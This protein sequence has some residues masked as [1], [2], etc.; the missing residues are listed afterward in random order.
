MD[1]ALLDQ[2]N[3]E[4]KKAV[5]H[6]E[7]P[8]LI[9]AGAGT[10]KTTVITKRI[11]WLIDQGLAKPEEI[12][13]LTFT[14]KAAGE[15]EERVDL[16]LPY[17]YVDLQ[18]ST[19]HA[20]CE[21]LL[22]DFGTQIGLSHQF[23]VLD[24]LETWL[25]ARQK[26]DRFDLDY[27]RPLG[28]PT[29][30]LRG[31]LAHFSRAKDHHITPETY[32]AFAESLQADADH[33][34]AD[35]SSDMEA[36]RIFELATAYQTYQQVLLEQDALDF[37]DL[38]LYTLKLLQERPNVLQQLRARYRFIL[39][40]EFQDTNPAQYELV[41]LLSEPRNNL[42]VVGDDDQAIYKFR[43]ASIENIL[44]FESDYPKAAR[45]V[46]TQNYRSVQAILD[47]A[48]TF[49][50][51]NNPDRLEARSGGSL[52]K[53]L[54][55]NQ[56]GAGLIEHL[57]FAT[58]EEE[59]REVIKKILALKAADP[60][61]LWSDIAVLV[62][63][64]G[65]G[66]DF[67]HGF[68]RSG[69][70]F[71]FLA[72]SGLYRKP[73]VVDLMSLLRVI[74][75][76]HDSPSLYRVLFLPMW[77]IP[78]EVL[79]ELSRLATRKGKSLFETIALAGTLGA[80]PLEPIVR[81]REISHLLLELSNEAKTKTASELF[82]RALKQTK[83]IDVITTLDD[84][85]KKEIFGY[86][87]QMLERVKSFEKRSPLPS[88]HE[89][90]AE[91]RHEQDAG[92]EGSLSVDIEAGPDVVRLMTV[93]AAKG[94]EFKYVF[95]VNLVDRRFP[96]QRRSDAIA[97]PS[98]LLSPKDAEVDEAAFHLQE[99]RR[100]F[101]VAMTRAKVGL[102]F[103]SAEDYGGARSRKLSRFLIELGYEKPST[104]E[105]TLIVLI[106]DERERAETSTQDL[107]AY[108]P[109]QFSFTQ[110]AAFQTCPLQYKFAHLLRVP[111]LGRWSLSFGK[112]MHNTLHRYFTAWMERTGKRQVGLFDGVRVKTPSDNG[113]QALPVSLEELLEMYRACWIDEWYPTDEAR[114]EYR[115]RGKEQLTR[116]AKSFE[117]ERPVPVALEQGYTYKIGDV[118]L[119]GRIDRID[120]FEDGV[121]I[122][123]YKTG[124]P[125]VLKQL[126]REDKEQLWLY[127]L[128][129][130]DVL[131]LYPKKLTFVYLEDQSRVSFLGSDEDL[132]RLQEEVVERV[133]RIRES[134]FPP[135]PGR[136]C[137]YCD[138]ADICEYR[139]L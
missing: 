92:E 134:D 5:T 90:L 12:L 135:N 8:L 136:H 119:K 43:G 82:V 78:A 72:L 58:S 26:L 114:E 47:R 59:V 55:S 89:F 39:V 23:E 86:L 122:I 14:D 18:I 65:A 28:N 88:L 56:P 49:I 115:K 44:R 102:F 66:A 123:D 138:F 41:R 45:V 17:G 118:I 53:R 128:A 97:L 27:Y 76:P 69:I 100:L 33:F 70:P 127:Q 25:L 120:A 36:Q 101:Y 116:Y 109:K 62:R 2:L 32:L 126:E 20:F 54:V 104:T 131:K 57:H 95:V 7:G 93:H 124:T 61:T 11:A 125:K 96:T 64:N 108:V 52:S 29:K 15:M 74:D 103:T 21:R 16:L 94:L 83:Y 68:E 60:E 4:Q 22:R 91:F 137:R 117:D 67:A 112:T 106:D 121:E 111:V 107:S 9:V 98:E 63:S 42:T 129:V 6:K 46:L 139:E 38:L 73:S 133:K 48:H 24:E 40:D 37:G 87:Q 132:L 99:E 130:R 75:Q 85:K 79:I 51:M 10:G 84:Q 1:T 34:Q 81:L 31:L 77:N 105:E 35:G 19:F 3:D 30:Y 80:L 71:Q 113:S 110:L 13:A 50:Q